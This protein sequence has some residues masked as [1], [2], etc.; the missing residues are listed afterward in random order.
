MKRNELH[1]FAKTKSKN[2]Q[3]CCNTCLHSLELLDNRR[4]QSPFIVAFVTLAVRCQAA[5]NGFV[6][7]IKH[8][9]GARVASTGTNSVEWT[10]AA[11]VTA[12]FVTRLAYAV[13]IGVFDR[14]TSRHAIRSVTDM[15]TLYAAVVSILQNCIK[16]LLNP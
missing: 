2:S 8:G 12:E 13:G 1:K 11:V 6:I 5:E 14:R 7:I 4:Q 10:S 16:F 15:N 3:L 9:D